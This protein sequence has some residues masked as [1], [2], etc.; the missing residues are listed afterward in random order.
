LRSKHK[1][2]TK[3]VLAKE[4]M[5]PSHADQYIEGMNP[6]EKK[7][8]SPVFSPLSESEIRAMSLE[9]IARVPKP[10]QEKTLETKLNNMGSSEAED[11]K[12]MSLDTI[13]EMTGDT[14][15]IY[16]AAKKKLLGRSTATRRDSTEAAQEQEEK[17]QKPIAKFMFPRSKEGETAFKT[18]AQDSRNILALLGKS[19]VTVDGITPRL[20]SLNRT[21][22]LDAKPGY[23]LPLT[24]VKKF[25]ESLRIRNIA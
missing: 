6:S 7:A 12:T 15:A 5:S 22:V 24:V 11:I 16:L 18:A 20:D 21:L 17:Y 13:N 23:T 3:E 2:Y 10:M 8:E 25:E 1:S 19:G 4:N 14:R 9:E